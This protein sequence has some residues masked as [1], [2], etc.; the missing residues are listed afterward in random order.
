MT[1]FREGLAIDMKKI[2]LS[3]TLILI[4]TLICSCTMELVEKD[5]KLIDSKTGITYV[6]APICFEPSH[7][8]EELF[9]KCKTLSIELYPVTGQSTELYIAEQYDGIGGL[10][11][12]E[13]EV[14]L[15]TLEEFSAEKIYI[16]VEGLI[17]TAIGQVTDPDDIAAIVD[18]FENGETCSVPNEGK[19]YK[20]KFESSEYPGIYY[21]LLYIIGDETNY[22]YDRSTKRCV[23]ADLLLEEYLPTGKKQERLEKEL[24]AKAAQSTDESD[25]IEE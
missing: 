17:T 25:D 23:D 8:D 6:S 21:N 13:G 18:V 19:S 22:I 4:I 16:C 24:A 20:L 15:P 14:T 11:Y 10:W 5:G 7:T 3:I 9:A 12:A 1:V 2:A